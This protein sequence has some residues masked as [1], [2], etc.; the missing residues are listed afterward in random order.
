MKKRVNKTAWYRNNN[1]II[2]GI[3][4][5]V[6]AVFVVQ[7]GIFSP[8][9]VNINEISQAYV[10]QP[11]TTLNTWTFESNAKVVSSGW[12]LYGY[13]GIIPY[14]ENGLMVIPG[15]IAATTG[16]WMNTLNIAASDM[17]NKQGLLVEITLASSN[18]NV[19]EDPTFFTM[20]TG[21][22]EDTTLA[23]SAFAGAE[24]QGTVSSDL[25]TYSFLFTPNQ[26]EEIGTIK[27]LTIG[28]NPTG[29]DVSSM[30]IKDIAIKTID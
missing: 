30:V 27:S 24:V 18:N 15:P 1:V 19:T 12:K 5:I 2:A 16:L 10:S 20:V 9:A 25:T 3:I 26:F 28:L 6:L 13:T 22:S 23:G 14:A 7:S 8:A 21:L 29:A 4:T 11:A 17:L